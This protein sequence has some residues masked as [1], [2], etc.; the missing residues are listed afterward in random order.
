MAG[1]VYKKG[2]KARPM[3]GYKHAAPFVLPGLI[4]VCLFVIYPM[5]FTF[6][7]AFSD[8][9][10]VKGIIN[11]T[12]LE[13]FTKIFTESSSRFWYAY[14]NNF[15]YAAVT[16]PFILFG[17]LGF[18]YLINSV[19]HFKTVF[20][21]GFYLPVLTSWV[22]VSLVFQY[23]FNSSSRGLVN[24]F[25]VDVFHIVKEYIPWLQREW[26]GN[27]AIWI[28]GIWKNLGWAMLIFFAAL[29]GIPS[30]L[31]EAASLDGASGFQKFRSITIPMVKPTI[32]FVLVNMIIGSFNVFIQV[33]LLTSG[34]PN[35]K[36]S[37]LQYLLYDK[38]FNQFK[39]G[40]AS[41]IGLVTAATILL[42]TVLLNRGLKL[43]AAEKENKP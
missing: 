28:M 5:I 31:Y 12:G 39:F 15:L 7:I 26:S 32:Y 14:R 25:L 19:K 34:N 42:V 38:A 43:D 40:E 30:E 29:Q 9:Q 33:L 10:I 17:G 23:M 16:V 27:A 37:T 36:T 20:K 8:Y 13:N 3:Q 18:A 22:I 21:V 1:N 2:R 6:R 4:L 35:G 41:A 11:F 24:Y